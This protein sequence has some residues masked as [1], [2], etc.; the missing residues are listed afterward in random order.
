MRLLPC[1]LDHAA[2]VASW[3]VSAAE[4]VQWCGLREFPV[5]GA[6]VAAWQREPDVAARVLVDGERLLGYG[7]LWFD[8]EEDE[9]ELA[10]LV[11]AP[12]VRGQ[13]LGRELVRG[14]LAEARLSGLSD[15]F[16]RVHPDNA[17]ALRCYRGAGFETVDAES[18]AAWNAG[19]PVA[20]VGLRHS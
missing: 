11:V 7:E 13:G 4:V 14:L 19:Q 15:V 20:Y 17:A 1:T 18:A 3:P 8:A 5:T 6:T 10:R 9:V 2:T 12:G 16:M